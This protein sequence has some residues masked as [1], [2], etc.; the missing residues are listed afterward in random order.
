MVPDITKNILSCWEH[1]MKVLVPT[2]LQGKPAVLCKQGCPLKG[3]GMKPVLPSNELRTGDDLWCLTVEPGHK[4]LQPEL[5][6][7]RNLNVL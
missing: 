5:K 1:S 6:V 3:I 2:V 7:A 4:L